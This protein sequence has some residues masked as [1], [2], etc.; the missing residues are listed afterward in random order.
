MPETTEIDPVSIA[1]LGQIQS[2]LQTIQ[3]DY[4][5]LAAAIDSINRKIDVSSEFKPTQDVTREQLPDSRMSLI[6]IPSYASDKAATSNP[7]LDSVL[8]TSGEQFEGIDNA[9]PPP[10]S[11]R[12]SGSSRIILTTYPGQ[13]G[14]DPLTMRWGHA[15]PKLRGPVVASRSQS[16][17]RR[18]NGMCL[19][20]LEIYQGLTSLYGSY[21]RSW[22]LILD[23]S[24]TCRCE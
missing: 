14:I 10:L 8:T 24:R 22:G 7:K 1:L 4:K 3:R 6:S 20:N 13:S 21:W 19:E 11:N 9:V 5:Q 12:S 23:I 17:I 2:T 18:R 15:D 16:T